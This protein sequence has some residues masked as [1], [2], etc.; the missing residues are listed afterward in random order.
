[1]KRVFPKIFEIRT[2]RDIRQL[3]VKAF[4]LALSGFREKSIF[5]K[6]TIFQKV[7]K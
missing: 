2:L 6:K 3:F 1:M 4:L 7:Q 5:A